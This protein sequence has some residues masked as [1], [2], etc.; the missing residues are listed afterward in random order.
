MF[1]PVSLQMTTTN[2]STE[3]EF[4]SNAP[5]NPKQIKKPNTLSHTQN[6]QKK[7][8][9]SFCWVRQQSNFSTNN[10]T[11]PKIILVISGTLNC[12]LAL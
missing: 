2:T 9:E 8:A 3:D 11:A 7:T 5:K 10:V 12:L 4:E 6:K 1:C